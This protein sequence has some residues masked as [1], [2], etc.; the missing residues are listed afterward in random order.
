MKV[1]EF[2]KSLSHTVI[3]SSSLSLTSEKVQR[4]YFPLLLLLLRWIEKNVQ[5]NCCS[6]YHQTHSYI[7][8]PNIMASLGRS[9]LALAARRPLVNA[10]AGPSRYGNFASSFA[11]SSRIQLDSPTPP[12]SSTATSPLDDASAQALENAL[13]PR[14]RDTK[15]QSIH[16]P[17]PTSL[18][19]STTTSSTTNRQP[20]QKS[21]YRI[22]RPA[23][24]ASGNLST[25]YTSDESLF[26]L[27]ITATRNNTTLTFSDI[28]GPLFPTI[29][30]GTDKTFKNSQRASYEAAHQATLKMFAKMEEYSKSTGQSQTQAAPAGRVFASPSY[31]YGNVSGIGSRRVKVVFVGLRGGQG[32]E[33]VANAISGT[34]GDGI[35]AFIGRVEDRTGVKIGGTRGKKRR[36]L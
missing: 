11:T 7:T 8:I 34:E 1:I 29:S 26:T 9:V 23:I 4:A 28:T 10:V 36:R 16:I 32:R 12:S 30:G 33:A 13:N 5:P 14:S 31:Q 25:I 17:L 24:P 18:S 20:I 22:P 27:T 3:Y 6:I 2:L 19:P 15:A 35:R 21:K